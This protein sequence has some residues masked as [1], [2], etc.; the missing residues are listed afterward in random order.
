MTASFGVG[1]PMGAIRR[2]MVR[3]PEGGLA[4]ED[5]P[6]RRESGVS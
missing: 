1:D 2:V 5:L 3:P 6:L 4:V